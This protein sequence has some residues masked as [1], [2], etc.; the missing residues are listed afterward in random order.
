MGV[1]CWGHHDQIMLNEPFC[2][3]F[4]KQ[5]ANEDEGNQM[6][7]KEHDGD[8]YMTRE[9]L[10]DYYFTPFGLIS[11][12]LIWFL[13]FKAFNQIKLIQPLRPQSF[14]Q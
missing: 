5:D 2:L 1:Y 14:N 9:N 10:D 13:S 4:K 8:D 11:S 12:N 6:E 3:H 7:M